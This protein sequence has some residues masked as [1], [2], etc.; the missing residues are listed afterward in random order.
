MGWQRFS[1]SRPAAFAASRTLMS[2]ATGKNGE[3]QP[4]HSRRNAIFAVQVE[5]R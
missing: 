4:S 5:P 2:R 3:V 1:M